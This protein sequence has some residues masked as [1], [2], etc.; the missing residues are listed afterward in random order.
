M[1]A[2]VEIILFDMFMA[3]VVPLLMEF[4]VTEVTLIVVNCYNCEDV[5]NLE[6]PGTK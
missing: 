2:V 1:W 6:W 4:A 3:L 5:T